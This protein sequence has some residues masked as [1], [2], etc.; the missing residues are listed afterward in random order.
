[1]VVHVQM[2]E[3]GVPL[4][5]RIDLPFVGRFFIDTF[6]IKKHFAGGRR[7]KAADD[8]QSGGFAAAGGAE[9]SEKFMVV[10]VEIDA[11]E[12]ALPVEL[13][14]EILEPDEFLGHY[15]P[16]FLFIV[17]YSVD[18]HENARNVNG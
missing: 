6:P 14:G 9:Q 17:F 7:Q 15:P 18:I 3:Q 1:M 10:D 4:K 2:R 13:H 12:Y 8:P 16:P 11:V 5:N